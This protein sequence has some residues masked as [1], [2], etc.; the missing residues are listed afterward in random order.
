MTDPKRCR[1][2]NR[3]GEQCG[4]PPMRGGHVCASHGG[5]T[6][7]ALAAAERRLAEEEATRQVA[8]LQGTRGSLTLPDVYRELL[9]TAGLAVAWQDVLRTRVEAL[10]DYSTV[11]GLGSP[12]VR[13]DVQLFERAMDRAAKV[14]ELVGRLDLD[15]RLA[16]I[17][18]D[19][20]RQVA[21]ILNRAMDAGDLTPEQRAAMS[22]ELAREIRRL[23]NDT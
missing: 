16:R 23:G 19:Q 13:A 11:N 12:V 14:L 6:P 4:R 9:S 3:A 18:E 2:T 22:V 5:K 17:T 8:R 15:S 7:R 21:G 10:E 1:A 20:G